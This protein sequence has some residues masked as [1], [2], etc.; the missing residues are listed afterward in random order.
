M[1]IRQLIDH[2]YL[3][4]VG[5]RKEIDALIGEA[6]EHRFKSVCIQPC[7][8]AYAKA[9]L[10][11]TGVL[12]CTVIG[13]PLGA[14]TTETKVFET[15]NAVA[16]GADEI[17]MVINIGELKAGNLD[18]VRSEIDSVVKAASGRLVK[19]IIETCY[20]TKDEIVAA[21]DIVGR[22]GATFVKTSTGFGPAGATPE[23]V[24]LMKANARGKEVKAA[25]GVRT[26]EDLDKMV[27]AGATRIGTSNGVALV[28][29]GQGSGY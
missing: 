2:T 11:R 8:V 9:K 20:L 26:R 3:K 23:D 10:E 21:S 24:R 7:F 22:T 5:T 19:V 25:G 27:D 18:Y 4:P 29:N 6:V 13:F 14:N 1:E 28:Q 17:D 12:V 16:N 15:L